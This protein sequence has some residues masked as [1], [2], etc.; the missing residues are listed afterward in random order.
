MS[1]VY[2]T[3]NFYVT[4]QGNRCTHIEC[5]KQ[6][7]HDPAT[8]EHCPDCRS[9]NGSKQVIARA[10]NS[11]VATIGTSKKRKRIEQEEAEVQ[12]PSGKRARRSNNF[13]SDT[14]SDEASVVDYDSED[15]HVVAADD[16]WQVQKNLNQVCHL[17]QENFGKTVQ[18]SVIE[19]A[20]KRAKLPNSKKLA[21]LVLLCEVLKE[22]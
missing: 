11:S 17:L 9:N 13:V 8:L 7:G 10:T 1:T 20:C 15:D 16:M 22:L 14:S 19:Q 18:V 5:E 4:L 6:N 21:S 12:L 2:V 3:D